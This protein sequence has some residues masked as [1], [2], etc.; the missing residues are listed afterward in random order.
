MHPAAS[1]FDDAT[2][3]RVNVTAL[4]DELGLGTYNIELRVTDD[5]GNQDTDFTTVVV[6][7]ECEQCQ[8][9]CGMQLPGDANQDG[10]IDLSDA[11]QLLHLLF[12]SPET[13]LPCEGSNGRNPG[14]GDLALLDWNGD[15]VLVSET[16]GV[17][18]IDV[19]DPVALLS[20][21]FLGN[22]PAHVLGRHCTLIAGCPDNPG[23]A[24]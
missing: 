17:P 1:G 16:Q 5:E 7:D 12:I 19:S 20:W 15:L 23:C 10:Q 3:A 14:S 21:Y 13:G 2:G 9:R 6:T 22:S 24:R 18:N 11:I 4:F 8:I